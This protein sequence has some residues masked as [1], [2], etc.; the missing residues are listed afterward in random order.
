VPAIFPAFSDLYNFGPFAL[1][2]SIENKAPER[3]EQGLMTI[4]STKRIN[5]NEKTSPG[6]AVRGMYLIPVITNSDR[7]ILK[8][9]TNNVPE[10]L[11]FLLIRLP[12]PEERSQNASA[13]LR[14]ISLPEKT[15]I[16][17]RTRTIFT[18]EEKKPTVK[19]IRYG[20]LMKG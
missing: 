6:K 7:N 8:N 20:L 15:A 18:I 4:I 19:I 12:I 14:T 16:V 17:S 5:N 2:E 10:E 9:R 11:I 3:K 13:I 1:Q